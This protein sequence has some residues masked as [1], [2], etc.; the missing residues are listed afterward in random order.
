MTRSYLSLIRKVLKC[1]S[2]PNRTGV[3]AKSLFGYQ[4]RFNLRNN[5]LPII[6]TKPMPFKTIAKELFWFMRGETNQK[7]LEN[8]G[9]KIWKGNSS[10]KY[11]DSRGLY[12]YKEYESLGPVYGFQWRHFGAKY[13]DCHTNYRECETSIDQ[14]KHVVETIKHDPESRRIIMTAWN[15]LDLPYMALP[16]C[17]ILIQFHVDTLRHELS[18]HLYQR[19]ADLMLGVPFNITSYSLLIH[20][21]A[22]ICNLK[23][24]EFIHSFGNVHIYDDHI[25]GAKEQLLRR[26]KPFPQLHI[27]FENTDVDD[28]I[29]N[30][31]CKQLKLL[32][33]NF[34]HRHI[35]LNMSV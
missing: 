27:Y 29:D 15:P 12:S 17:H 20:I 22:K 7:I 8:Q 10:R 4:L 14:L 5:T 18:A 35:K 28:I 6:T 23:C 32:N 13:V 30:L 33:Y 1:P 31:D 11:L 19:S 24:G 21:I 3:D 34:D 2:V 26:P 25:E 16:P 9:V